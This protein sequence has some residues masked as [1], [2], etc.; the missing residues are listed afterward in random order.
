MEISAKDSETLLTYNS[1]K[2]REKVVVGSVSKSE[3]EVGGGGEGG[4]GKV[5]NGR[6]QEEERKEENARPPRGE[7][8]KSRPNPRLS[9]PPKNIHG[10]QVAAGWPSWLSAVAGEA[11]NGWTPRRA[12]SFEKI[13]K[14]SGY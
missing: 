5:Q 8:R 3:E 10:E 14:A 13:D 11:I 6:D 12:D 7:R 2:R 9:N 1:F 4:G